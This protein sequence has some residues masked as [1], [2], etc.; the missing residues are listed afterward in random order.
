MRLQLADALWQVAYLLG[1]SIRRKEKIKA[2]RVTSFTYLR[3]HNKGWIG[4]TI[5]KTPEWRR[6]PTFMICQTICALV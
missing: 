2:G 6:E 1:V 4:K 5:R 3:D